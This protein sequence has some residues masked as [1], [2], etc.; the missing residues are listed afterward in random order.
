M[1]GVPDEVVVQPGDAGRPGHA[2]EPEQRDAPDVLPHPD[3]CGDAG[4]DR[5]RGQPGD[6]RRHHDVD[7]L[8]GEA[9]VGQGQEQRLGREIDRDPEELVV[10]LAEVV[11]RRVPLE[12]Q[13]EVPGADTRVGVQPLQR[14]HLVPRDPD[15]GRQRGRDVGLVVPVAGQ[16]AADG[17]D[18][19]HLRLLSV[20]LG[21]ALTYLAP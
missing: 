5:R 10:G 8:G 17:G 20:V 16:G 7:V 1:P 14:R 12:R 15:R 19:G 9:G 21:L 3:G 11:E 2:A 18:A 4:V 13:S 6:G